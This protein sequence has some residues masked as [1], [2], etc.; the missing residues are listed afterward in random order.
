MQPG[1]KVKVIGDEY[2]GRTGE[3]FEIYQ[4]WMGREVDTTGRT[5]WRELD[6][7]ELKNMW[8]VTLD[9]GETVCIKEEYL[10]VTN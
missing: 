6:A 5:E 1:D 8:W 3:I 10:E 4:A 2:R 9:N 7:K